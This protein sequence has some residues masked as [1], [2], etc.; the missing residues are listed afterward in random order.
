MT[1]VVAGAALGLSFQPYNLWPLLLVA[2]PALTLAV[3]GVPVR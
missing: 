2:L 1:A 3:R